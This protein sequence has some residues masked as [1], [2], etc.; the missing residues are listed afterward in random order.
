MA[1]FTSLQNFVDTI[2][3][4]LTKPIRGVNGSPGVS[5]IDVLE[6]LKDTGKYTDDMRVVA[7]S[8]LATFN[9]VYNPALNAASQA[10]A[11]AAAAQALV[12]GAA[13]LRP[14]IRPS[15]LLDF[16]NSNVLDPR[17]T[18]YRSSIGTYVDAN[19]NIRTAAANE[20]RIGFDQSTGQK[21]GLL[22]EP[23]SKNYITHSSDLTVAG[24]A[25][26]KIAIETGLTVL[27]VPNA[28]KIKPNTEAAEHTLYWYNAT[29][30]STTA[31]VLT[32][33]AIVSP[34]DMR[35]VRL[36]LAHSAFAAAS[37][38]TF[39]L[40]TGQKLGGI[41]GTGLAYATSGMRQLADGRWQIWL[42]GTTNGTDQYFTVAL[43]VNSN[44]NQGAYSG[45]GT[46]GMYVWEV[47]VKDGPLS[48]GLPTNGAAVTRREDVLALT[49]TNF[50]D[51][52]NPAEG[53][54]FVEAEY[55]QNGIG[56]SAESDRILID[57]TLDGTNTINLRTV[58]DPAS[59]K[60]DCY[61][62]ANN[63]IEFDSAG[64]S[65]VKGNTY[66]RAFSF[67]KN[68]AVEYNN[69]VL[70]LASAT[71]QVPIGLNRLVVPAGALLAIKCIAFFPKRLS[72]TELQALTTSGLLSGRSANQ[73]PT[74]GDLG[75]AAF[76]QLRALLAM[77]NRQEFQ[78]EGSGVS[79]T[80]TIRR[81]Y[82]F[83]FAL[84]DAMGAT[85]TASPSTTA[86]S[87]R[88]TNYS[89]TFNASAGTLLTYSITPIY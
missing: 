82:D 87:T 47:E 33:S 10:A 60:L 59:P 65:L 54:L 69:G 7:Q 26:N 84:V 3:T 57:N 38:Q 20:P 77:R 37:Q 32:V 51:W 78:V 79:R 11:S 31:K 52:F 63:V 40:T 70:I 80:V 56:A 15:L 61:S 83:Q 13:T 43:Y 8:A 73:L 71:Y 58:L 88:D 67:K 5:S 66:K 2:T 72:N 89:L 46:D 16:V 9:A 23:L 28:T 6:A 27:G 86:A 4:H 85:V 30:G 19:G 81:P 62:R 55:L 75:S 25:K 21:N 45:N 76:V 53:T 24:W 64:V 17:L 50:S 29:T 1:Y 48:S 34:G 35:Y 68:D 12:T 22:I 14:G 42:T 36:L 18:Y 39:D 44:T 74:V 41:I 49:G